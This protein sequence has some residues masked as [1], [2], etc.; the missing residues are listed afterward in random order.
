MK[1]GRYG[2]EVVVQNAILPS[3]AQDG[4]AVACQLWHTLHGEHVL[5]SC[6]R[7]LTAGAY[8]GLKTVFFH[9]AIK[10]PARDSRQA[11]GFADVS[12]CILEVALQFLALE[13]GHDA[14]LG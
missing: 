1:S 13:G 9:L 14:I 10:G 3:V 12:P 4:M 6:W 8:E 7:M 2:G 5:I 11:T